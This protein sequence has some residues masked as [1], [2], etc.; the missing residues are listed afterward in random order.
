M[1]INIKLISTINGEGLTKGKSYD[2][3]LFTQ[4]IYPNEFWYRND[5]DRL[6]TETHIEKNWVLVK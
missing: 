6:V 2:G 4:T 1:N 5:N 3:E